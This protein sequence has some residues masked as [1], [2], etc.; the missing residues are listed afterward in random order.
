[1]NKERIMANGE[2]D[3]RKLGL[4]CGLEIHQQLDTD[5]LFSYTPSQVRDD[6]PDFSVRRML[7]AVSGETGEKD[8]AAVFAESSRKNFIYEG[9]RDTISS[10]ELDEEPPRLMDDE[11][12]KASLQISLMLD[13]SIVDEIQVMRKTVVD[14]SNTSGFQRTSLVARNGSIKLN[15][16]SIG[17]PTI[18][19]EEDSAKIVRRS[20]DGQTITYNLSRLGIPLIEIGTKPDITTPAMAKEVAEKLGMMLRST[21]KVK[22]GLGTIRQDLNVSITGG[23]RI[24]IKGAQDLRMI[25]EWIEKEID[26]QLTLLSI[27]DWLKERPDAKVLKT[28]HDVSGVFD[29]TGSRMIS[30]ALGKGESVLA[31]V[32][33]GF[34]GVLAEEIGPGR[35]VGTELSDYAKAASGLKGII[36]S[37]EDLSGYSMTPKEISSLR[38]E[39]SMGKDDLFVLVVGRKEIAERALDAVIDRAGLLMSRVPKEVRR[40]NPDGTTSFMRPMPGSARMYPETDCAPVATHALLEEINVPELIDEKSRRYVSELSLSKDL[41]DGVSKFDYSRI[42]S[43]DISSFDDI[44]KKYKNLEPSFI[45]QAILSYPKEVRKRL[46]IEFK[47]DN[48]KEIF[49]LLENIDAGEISKDAFMELLPKMIKK[50][51]ID[52]SHYRPV[53]ISTVKKRISEIVKKNEGL[54]MGGLMGL[55]M[56][57]FRG[58]VDGKTLSEILKEE[59]SKSGK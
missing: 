12:L 23:A 36:H 41:A 44:L 39:L 38:K 56:K 10:V 11:A 16:G 32:M 34:S 46:G 54:P 31:I 28:K 42:P 13:A 9:Y 53:D 27:K 14:G 21:G 3:Y 37:D 50:E 4:K 6:A 29:G 8:A 24:E 15:H 47:D 43:M 57:E 48:Y 55:C 35:R 5:K 2:K 33:K 26:R 52:Y 30:A 17:V 7:R 1:M 25:P 20:D 40:T 51:K 18:S 59:M 19:L 22:R 49:M 45:A 58:K